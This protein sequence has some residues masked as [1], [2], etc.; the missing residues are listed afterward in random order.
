MQLTT[1]GLL[2]AALAA[3]SI[4]AGF[5]QLIRRKGG[6]SHRA[7]GY[8]YV[9]AMLV[10]DSSALAIR[11]FTGG[12]NVLHAGAV[13]NFG[14]IVAAMLPMLRRPRRPDRFEVHYR[15]MSAAYIGLIAAAATE[16]VV[17]LGPF[18]TKAQ[19]WTATGVV[20]LIVMSVGALLIGRYYPRKSTR[21][22]DLTARP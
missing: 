9:A 5:V 21:A 4:A 20:T 12:F 1:I 10:A 11:Q 3:F 13:V 19:L 15:W 18:T 8:A 16:L 7:L 14:C 17:R 22:G 6:P 2:H